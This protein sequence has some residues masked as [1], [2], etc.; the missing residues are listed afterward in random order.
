[1]PP[2]AKTPSSPAEDDP[3]WL[4][5]VEPYFGS[6]KVLFALNPEG[7]SEVANDLDGEI[8]N[9]FD[10][11]KSP[12]HFP[13]FQCLAALTPVSEVECNR[14]GTNTGRSPVEC[15]LALLIRNRQSCQALGQD[16]VTP[17]HKRTRR[18]MDEHV[19]A[20]LSAVDG[21]AVVHARLQRVRIVNRPALD[22]IRTEDGPRT[23]HY[24]D[25]PYPA[26]VRVTRDCYREFE[27][28]QADHRDLLDT[29]RQVRGR[30]MLSGYHCPLYDTILADWNSHEVSCPNHAAGGRVKRRMLEA[31]WC[32]F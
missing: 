10:V 1:M 5:Y 28:S 8:T 7:I 18:G 27:M 21:L 17:L 15:A 16:F 30:V 6:G 11:L 14:A 32:N 31:V 20:W 12:V 4:H 22:V 29:I 25:P 13:E 19:S 26:E 23:L 9:F 3:G 2:R 24:L